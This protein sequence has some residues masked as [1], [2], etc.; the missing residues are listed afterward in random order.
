M[1]NTTDL[2]HKEPSTSEFPIWL[3]RPR[4]Q[5]QP[6]NLANTGTL[7]DQA[8]E[9]PTNV[10]KDLADADPENTTGVSADK[11]RAPVERDLEKGSIHRTQPDG[12]GPVGL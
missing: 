7:L 5:Q 1:Y 3:Y 9:K 2:S 11:S 10:R 8:R 6:S 4:P 12:N